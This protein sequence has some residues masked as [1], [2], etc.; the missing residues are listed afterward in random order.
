MSDDVG[1]E[2]VPK[3][4]QE[5]KLSV[6]DR[7]NFDKEVKQKVKGKSFKEMKN[8]R[9]QEKEDTKDRRSQDERMRYQGKGEFRCR[10][11]EN[12]SQEREQPLKK[13][14]CLF[15]QH[16]VEPVSAPQIKKIAFE[17]ETDQAILDR[18]AVS[19]VPQARDER[20]GDSVVKRMERVGDS[21]DVDSEEEAAPTC[22][23]SG[24]VTGSG[25]KRKSSFSRVVGK[26]R[27]YAVEEEGEVDGRL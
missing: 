11:K 26:I 8:R 10:G 18:P 5:V 4:A 24:G 15:Y 16:R 27:R 2:Q 21:L 20:V 23:R 12:R 22:W 25:R 13:K 3:V 7:L 9:F 17:Q 19:E 14:P 6:F 1:G